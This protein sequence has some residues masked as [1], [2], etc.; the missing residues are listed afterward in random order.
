MSAASSPK[1]AYELF[2]YYRVRADQAQAAQAAFE[3]ERA[4]RPMRLLQRHDPDPS[5]LTWMEVYPAGLLDAETAMATV[6]GP[7][8]QGLR[9][10]ETFE[11]LRG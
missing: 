7:F 4:G 2:V 6:M 8:V 10:R 3:A 11:P 1:P 9:H 5:L